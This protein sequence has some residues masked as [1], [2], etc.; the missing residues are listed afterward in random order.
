MRKFRLKNRESEE[1]S[2]QEIAKFKDFDR[3]VTNYDKALASIHKK[4]LYK[5]PRTFIILVIIVLMAYLISEAT[6]ESDPP[7]EP[8]TEQGA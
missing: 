4:P 3:V 8:K 5:Q 7:E 1:L 6:K 2:D